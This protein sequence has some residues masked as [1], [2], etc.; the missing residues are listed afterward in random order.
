MAPATT[1]G[2][3]KNAPRVVC[4]LCGVAFHTASKCFKRF[5]RNFLGLGNDGANT[6]RQ[7]AMAMTAQGGG[8]GGGHG[9]QQSVDPAW[10]A[11]SGATH[12]V[13]H[14]LD[15]L[16]T[17]EPYYGTDQVH[18]ANGRGMRIHNIGHA[19]LP[20]PS[21]KPLNLNRVLHVPDAT[22]SVLSMSILSHDNNVF[23]ELHPYDFFCKVS[24]HEGAHS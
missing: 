20:T 3:K 14:E 22:S 12:H 5:N 23:I 2:S 9:G 7:V 19:L 11:D 21:S 1:S 8:Y 16:T 18:A 15:R 6:D 24:G 4:Q 13:T 17:K 10:Y